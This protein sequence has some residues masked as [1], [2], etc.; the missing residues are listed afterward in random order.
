MPTLL[1]YLPPVLQNVREFR[2]ITNAE[3]PEIDAAWV[4]LDT[5]LNDQFLETASEEGVARWEKELSILPLSSD[6]LESR[7]QR[8]KAAWLCGTAYTYRWLCTWLDTIYGKTKAP[9]ITDYTARF[10][11]P[12]TADYVRILRDL[13]SYLPAHLALSACITLSNVLARHYFG[14]AYRFGAKRT[15]PAESWDMTADETVVGYVEDDAGNTVADD[16]GKCPAIAF[17]TL[18]LIGNEETT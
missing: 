7:K 1:E 11:V 4:A 17:D 12:I 2:T 15:V 13:R 14:T 8:I 5:V 16:S 3:Q 18:I 10:F 6:T 9:S